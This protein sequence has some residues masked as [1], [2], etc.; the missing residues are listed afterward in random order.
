MLCP[1]GRCVLCGAPMCSHFYVACGSTYCI[2]SLVLGNNKSFPIHKTLDVDARL[3]GVCVRDPPRP[4][5]TTTAQHFVNTA[6]DWYRFLMN[7]CSPPAQCSGPVVQQF[8]IIC[9]YFIYTTPRLIFLK[10]F[11]LPNFVWYSRWVC[12]FGGVG[13]L[14]WPTASYTSELAASDTS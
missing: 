11:D 8:I 5:P 12:A 2:K 7:A 10:T 6:R 14:A 9:V 4:L 13:R 1:G 3:S